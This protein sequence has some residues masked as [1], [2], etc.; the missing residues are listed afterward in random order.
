MPVGSCENLLIS[1]KR[2]RSVNVNDSRV[3]LRRFKL[4][5]FWPS[6]GNFYARR[7]IFPIRL[8][9]LSRNEIN[10]GSIGVSQTQ[11]KRWRKPNSWYKS[12]RINVWLISC[13]NWTTVM[14]RWNDLFH[15]NF[16]L[17]L[18]ISSPPLD[19]RVFI[20][21]A[22]PSYFFQELLRHRLI[23][24]DWKLKAFVWWLFHGWII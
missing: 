20:T 5:T 3:P 17:S 2:K 24:D 19:W 22:F 21:N 10:K 18:G 6:P 13:S 4:L 14:S 8:R 7:E 1:L 15:F 16:F 9:L 11:P 12:S 23:N